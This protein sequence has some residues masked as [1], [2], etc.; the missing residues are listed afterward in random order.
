MKTPKVIAEIGCN[1]KGDMA[2]AKEMIMVA[3][4][5]C[6]ADVIKFQ[7][8]NPSELLTE[9]EYHAPHPNPMHAYGNTY[10]EH[11]EFLELSLSQHRQLKE[12]CEELGAVY[13]T[14]VWDLTSARE[15]VQLNPQLI[16]IPS[17]CNLNFELLEFLCSS[18]EGEI[19]IS[20]GMTTHD[21]EEQVISFFESKQRA[22]DVIVYSCTSGYPVAFEDICLL[23]ITRLKERFGSRV[24]E[25]GFSGHHLGI[26]ADV[27]AMTLGA[28]WIERHYTL[29]RTWKGTDH[30]ASLE[31]DGL[32]RL[33]RDIRHVS[34]ALEY[35]QNE[36]LDV[37]KVQRKKLKRL[38]T[39]V[40]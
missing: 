32:R 34:T 19:H 11:R 31:P 26:A 4:S 35:K 17:A 7:K 8:R 25:I 1:H 24:K 13:S 27:A 6:K 36:L 16:K 20:F 33:V 5:F 22:K 3:A 38:A 37:E 30:A 39:S 40:A 23:E 10:G 2:I 21:E 29:D 28:T 9:E 12:W 14:S 18:Y 15:I